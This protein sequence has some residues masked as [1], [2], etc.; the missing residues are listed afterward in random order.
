MSIA[1]ALSL[2][3]SIP[4]KTENSHSTFLSKTSVGLLSVACHPRARKT[5]E[6][7]APLWKFEQLGTLRKKIIQRAGRLTKPGGKLTLTMDFNDAAKAQL[8]GYL[9][10]LDATA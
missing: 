2:I 7:R 6:K 1:S 5:T 8:L 4:A 9:M 10:C 3:L